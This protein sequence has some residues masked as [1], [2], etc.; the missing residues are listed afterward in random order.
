MSSRVIVDN[1]SLQHVGDLLVDG[2]S[3]DT[4]STIRVSGDEHHYDDISEAVI[5]TE[6]LFDLL[7]QIVLTDEVLIDSTYS[8][9]WDT[10]DSPLHNLYRSKLIRPIQFLASEERFADLR[11]HIVERLCVTPSLA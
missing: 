2:V 11:N 5:Q 3:R 4:A 7:T 6:T 1:W 10:I 8:Y 9:T